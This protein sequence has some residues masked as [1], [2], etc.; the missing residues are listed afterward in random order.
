[1]TKQFHTYKNPS[2]AVDLAVFGYHGKE[3]SVLL[4]NRKE[5]PF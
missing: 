2:L 5:E 1:M 4:L 3:L